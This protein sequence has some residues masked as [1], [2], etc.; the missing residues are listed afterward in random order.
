[1]KRTHKAA[2]PHDAVAPDCAEG[3]LQVN[4]VVFHARKPP[5]RG[6][7]R[8]SLKKDLIELSGRFSAGT[9]GNLGIVAGTYHSFK[10]GRYHDI[11]VKY[12]QVQ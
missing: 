12:G 6:E 8:G 2:P 11:L 1:M 7:P 10:V 3:R 4:R 5:R 9:D